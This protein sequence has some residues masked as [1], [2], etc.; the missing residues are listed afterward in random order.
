MD[1]LIKIKDLTG[2]YEISA[3]TLRYYEDMGLIASTR[4]NG[5][6]YR[7]YDESAVKRLE[8]I[9][10][11]RRLNISIKDI[12][13]VFESPGS[14]A[15]LEVLDKKIN[16]I[17]DEVALLHELKEVILSFIR[18]IQNADFSSES[19]VKLL[20]EKARDIETQ[21]VNIDYDGNAANVNRLM[22]VAER[23]EKKPEVV[24][25]LPHFYNIFNVANPAGTY[26]LYREAFGAEKVSEDYP[27]GEAHIG[28]EVNGFYIL[29]RQEEEP[30]AEKYPGQACAVRFDDAEEL[31]RAYDVLAKDGKKG[32]IMRD[33]GWSVMVA[34]VT[35][36]CGVSWFFC[37]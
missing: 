25:K 36:C 14:G 33:V 35:D 28:I 29:L 13:R 7:F 18:Q 22:E 32:E 30:V 27:N 8:Q 26:E 34:W 2:R 23:L 11:L 3:R 17:D 4:Q 20:Y 24:R 12:R 19:D 37:V 21:I 1:S 16:D 6:A 15:V 5:Y 9:L 10:I 31:Q